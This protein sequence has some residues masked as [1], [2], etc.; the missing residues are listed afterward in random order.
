MKKNA[1]LIILLFVLFAS[2]KKQNN[3]PVITGMVQQQGGCLPN[4][5]LVFIPGGNTDK[6]PF[7][8]ASQ[9]PT[10]SFNCSNSVY[11]VNMPASLSQLGTRVKFSRWKDNGG[12]CSS[13]T[14]APHH[15]EVSDLTAE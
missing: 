11:I 4:T 3:Y 13:S 9:V 2:C 15:L 7:L 1:I 14:F 8:C 10:S 12:S 5:W 6:H